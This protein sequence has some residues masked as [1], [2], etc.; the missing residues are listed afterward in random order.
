MLFQ[1]LFLQDFGNV[2][3]PYSRS[4]PYEET[5]AETFSVLSGL[6]CS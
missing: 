3:E 4:P 6:G 5:S 2:D 1:R